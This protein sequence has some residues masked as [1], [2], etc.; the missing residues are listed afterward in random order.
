MDLSYGIFPYCN[1]FRLAVPVPSRLYYVR[2]EE[3]P[4]DG[5]RFSVKD[6][7]DLSGTKT[8]LAC[9]SWEQ[10]YP[11]CGTTAVALRRILDLGGIVV[12]KT[13]L[14]QFAEVEVP[15]VDWVDFHCPFNPRGDGYLLPQGSTSGGAVALAAYD[16]L[17]VSIGTDSVYFPHQILV[18]WFLTSLSRRKP[19]RAIIAARS[20]RYSN[21]LGCSF[22]HWC[23]PTCVV[24][25]ILI[26]C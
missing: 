15:T 13:K 3:R 22:C 8:T 23:I 17:D 11:P 26:P 2:N 12:G 25:A 7:I 14:S 18:M 24:R 9:R 21:K 4:L 20:L 16:W 6:N 1:G 19:E 5:L 10:L